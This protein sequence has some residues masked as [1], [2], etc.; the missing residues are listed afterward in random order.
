MPLQTVYTTVTLNSPRT[1]TLGYSIFP[2]IRGLME[3]S[4]LLS[5]MSEYLSTSH[6]LSPEDHQKQPEGRSETD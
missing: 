4:Y 5:E 3:N 1:S 6:S 2:H